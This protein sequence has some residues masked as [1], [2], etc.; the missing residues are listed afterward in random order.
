[1]KT[2]LDDL[3]QLLY[4]N[5]VRRRRRMALLLALSLIVTSSVVWGLHGV[6]FTLVN[7]PICGQEEHQHGDE[8]YE[9]VLACG[10]EESE[11]HVHS[12]ECHVQ[13]LTC[14]L[15]EH[16]H[17]TSC[18]VEPDDETSNEDAS[19]EEQKRDEAEQDE[20]QREEQQGELDQDELDQDEQ[21]SEKDADDIEGEDSED[22][23]AEDEEDELSEDEEDLDN[24]FMVLAAPGLLRTADN[25]LDGIKINLFDYGTDALDRSGNNFGSPNT[26]EGINAGRSVV[27]DILFFAYGTPAAGG[28]DGI[29]NPGLNN[30][31][32]DYG[33]N[34]PVSGNRPVQNIVNNTLSGNGYPTLRGSGHS[35]DYLFNL[36]PNGDT[37][38]VYEDVSFLM[39]KDQNGRYQYI[40]DRNYAYL[41]Q[42]TGNFQVYDGTFEIDMGNSDE[43][44]GRPIGF[45][46][47][48]AYDETRTN[49]NYGGSGYDHHFG[50]TMTV[51]FDMTNIG[52]S[53][54][55]KGQ[56]IEFSYSGDDDMW[57]F[58]DD[59]LVLDL[60]GIH[61]PA[62]GQI[63]FTKG[64]VLVQDN[65]YGTS[66]KAGLGD[67]ITGDILND[68]MRGGDDARMNETS[69][70]AMFAAA[71]R[72]W[73]IEDKHTLKVFYLERGGC[74]SNLA[75]EFNLPMSE[76]LTVEKEVQDVADL[77]DPNMEFEYVLLVKYANG[78][79]QPH[80]G[81]KY[82]LDGNMNLERTTGADGSFTLRH[83]Q[84]ALFPSL[85]EDAE[86]YVV[87]KGV[88]QDVFYQ[89]EIV[90]G[91]ASAGRDV[92]SLTDGGGTID[93]P[94]TLYTLDQNNYL[95]FINKVR[96]ESGNVSVE[97]AWVNRENNTPPANTTIHFKLY[98]T[99][100]NGN[101]VV[102]SYD[103]KR[104]FALNSG[105]S[106]NA[107]FTNLPTRIGKHRYT[108]SVE[109]LD[110]PAGYVVS[111]KT[112]VNGEVITVTM[113]NTDATNAEIHVI[114]EWEG[115]SEA[116]RNQLTVKG[117]L[118]RQYVGLLDVTATAVTINVVDANG[119]AITSATADAYVGGSFEFALDL[120]DGAAYVSHQGTNCTVARDNEFY[121]V[122]DIKAGAVVTITINGA[123]G[124]A[125]PIFHH[126]FTNG[127]DG[128]TRRGN[129][130]VERSTGTQYATPYATGSML[131]VTNRSDAWN[132]ARLQINPSD[133][134]P[135]QEYSF[136]VQAMA[137][138]NNEALV[139]Q[140]EYTSTSTRSSEY[141]DIVEATGMQA[142]WT[143]LSNSNYR[144]PDDVN[145][146]SPVYIYVQTREGTS[147]FYI[148]EPVA[149]PGG[150]RIQVD[151]NGEVTL[152]SASSGTCTINVNGDSI[153]SPQIETG[154]WT[155]DTGWNASDA[156]KFTLDSAGEWKASWD[157]AQLSQLTN[158]RYRY[159][160]EETGMEG[161]Y[162]LDLFKITYS[163]DGISSNTADD[164]MVICN[165]FIAYTLPVT[166]GVGT[167]PYRMIGLLLASMG[168]LGCYAERKRRRT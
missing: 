72:T 46:P 82:Y 143:E 124:P 149:A 138:R 135:G 103:G 62:A 166:G 163:G 52:A 137:T 123:S 140:L 36:T 73:T 20:Q 156:A 112:T 97:K 54:Q 144:I 148:D 84:T 153:T 93:V 35:L 116:V 43:H 157:N 31:A 65:A 142:Q 107:S 68:C 79:F 127:T 91:A 16:S 133:F 92:R 29:T 13:T 7:E 61:E 76:S 66:T 30:Y 96:R 41:D 134:Q 108:Y 39:T 155:D 85:A 162:S 145:T 75:L 160:V 117:V 81:E 22:E 126:S 158:R 47:F 71:G 113:T 136:Y 12:E 115:I 110:C 120:P 19:Q 154:E 70:A 59:V 34:P 17:E 168:I 51:D 3:C 109:E 33:Q 125:S 146:G 90:P 44:N 150:C 67:K 32:G 114:K 5:R 58:L 121:E 165:K 9:S 49:P 122:T 2:Y 8:C 11:E 129:E 69:I 64:Y 141:V 48:D 15:E 77:D 139:L 83:G 55:Y 57:V 28:R 159:Y 37:K 74:Y 25:R 78:N 100:E 119:N 10:V 45:F 104:T 38:R 40:S 111:Y 1:M 53:L 24:G 4:K 161:D 102:V 101:K 106:W 87:E 152:T 128:W 94:S 89:V 26:S 21:D 88:E 6:G 167:G 95:K 80:A 131:F 98:R 18:Y 151:G 132:G 164:P 27:D 56:D 14:T 105:N 60:G 50:M 118:K 147:N 130:T 99:D 63:N 23:D 42:S 86:Y